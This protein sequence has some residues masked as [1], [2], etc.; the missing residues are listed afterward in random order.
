MSKALK[1]IFTLKNLLIIMKEADL[2]NIQKIKC[3]LY[4]DLQ[5]KNSESL[6]LDLLE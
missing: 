1:K 4:F 2:V 5:L 3:Y 6:C